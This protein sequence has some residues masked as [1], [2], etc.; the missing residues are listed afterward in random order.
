MLLNQGVSAGE[1][2]ICQPSQ[3]PRTQPPCVWKEEA[4]GNRSRPRQPTNKET[5]TDPM[6]KMLG[7]T[8][9]TLQAYSRE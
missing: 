4:L 7:V 9:V 8:S 1:T 3:P 5:Q 2:W 6:D